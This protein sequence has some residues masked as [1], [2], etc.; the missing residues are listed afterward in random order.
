MDAR[1]GAIEQVPVIDL[2]GP[3]AEVEG[4]VARACAEWGFFHIVGHGLDAG[5]GSSS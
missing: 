5:I 2:S 4:A 3:P 1:V